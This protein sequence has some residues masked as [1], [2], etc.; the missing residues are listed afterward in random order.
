MN[1]PRM[2]E[3]IIILII[4]GCFVLQPVSTDLYLASL[5]HLVTEFGVSA[6]IVQQTLSFFTVGFGVAQLISGP[7]SDRFG[8]RPMML[9]GLATYFVASMICAMA[10]SIYVLI[11]GR[12]LQ[13][14]GCCT[15]VVVARAI[16]RDCY[17]PADG[18]QRIARVSNYMGIAVFIGPILGAQLQNFFGWRA[19]FMLHTLL[20]LSV[21]LFAWRML[22]ETNGAPNPR[23]TNPLTLGRAYV[24][25]S[26]SKA[27]WAYALPGCLSYGSIFVFISGASFAYIK[28]LGVST[29]NYGYCFSLGC[30]GY[31]LGS[32]LCRKLLPKLGMEKT[33]TIGS[34]IMLLSGTVFLVSSLSG[35]E[36]WALLALCQFGSMFSHGL[37]F[38][39]AQ[40]GSVAPFPQKAGT[41]AGLFGAVS[42]LGTLVV[43]TLIGLHLKVDLLPMATL[44]FAMS[45]IL[46]LATRARSHVTAPSPA[47]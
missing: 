47:A 32:Y 9:A 41:A 35:M 39:T 25:L 34:R 19:A 27:F 43:T 31:L 22:R 30:A 18:A 6:V 1:H 28:V 15:G 42:V 21:L 5:P 3:H 45:L 11:G 10:P 17:S 2:A 36:H 13:A 26:R 23:A 37:I 12:F 4:T 38:P 8:R 46:F 24:D 29:V 40:A 14:I 20:S 44:A 7:L 16:I 33:I